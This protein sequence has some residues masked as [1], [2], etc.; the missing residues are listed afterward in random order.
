[1]FERDGSA[2]WHLKANGVD[3]NLVVNQPQGKYQWLSLVIMP[4]FV[5][6]YVSTKDYSSGNYGSG[7][8][9]IPSLAGVTDVLYPFSTIMTQTGVQSKMRQDYWEWWEREAIYGRFGTSY[10]Q[11]H[12]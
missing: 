3:T 2:Y 6:W 10:N 9:M 11:N 8:V 12:P 1:M 5:T 4:T 7:T